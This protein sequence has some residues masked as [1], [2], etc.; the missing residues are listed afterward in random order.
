MAH[1]HSPSGVNRQPM[2][3]HLGNEG[4]NRRAPLFFVKKVA[5]RYDLRIALQKV[6]SMV[7]I[8]PYY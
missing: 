7:I 8:V 3:V 2:N 6:T 4:G 1:T 5:L